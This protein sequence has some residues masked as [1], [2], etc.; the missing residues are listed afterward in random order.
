MIFDNP[1]TKYLSSKE[2]LEGIDYISSYISIKVRVT[3]V[4]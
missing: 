3:T 4:N 2:F 1:P